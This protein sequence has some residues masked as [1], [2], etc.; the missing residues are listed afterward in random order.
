MSLIDGKWWEENQNGARR[1]SATCA[2]VA[3]VLVLI[4]FHSEIKGFFSSHSWWENT[5]VVL[6]GVA[7][8]VLAYFEL[9]HSGEAN[10][11]RRQ[12]NVLRADAV[13]LQKMIGE[14]EAEKAGHLGQIAANTQRLVTQ[15][16][17]N[18]DILRRHMGAC[19]SVT[20][21]QGNWPSTPLIVEVSEANIVMLFS[22]SAGSNPQAWCVQVDCGELEV[23][24][25]PHGACPLRLRV[26]RR[27]GPNVPL[28]EIT[29]W[30]DRNLPAAAP[31]FNRGG[32]VYH[33]TFS[34]PGSAETRSLHVYA[35]AG[36]AN[37]FLLET[38]AGERVVADNVEI[39][40]RF[41]LFEIDYRSAGFNRSGSGTGGSPHQLF[42]W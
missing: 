29:R 1:L 14:S 28:G 9:R 40:R 15:A 27:Y 12:A 34:R 3:L 24:E 16:Q 31:R 35:S 39:S 18:A 22:P 23:A 38:L 33:A 42:I 32:N 6:A 17:R 30:E 7:V 19:A 26:L 25:I 10:E 11:L 2:L 5:L 20:E 13:R 8:P 21:G 41:M 36:G 37:S 4:L